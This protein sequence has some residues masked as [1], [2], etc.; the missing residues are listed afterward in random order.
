M[1]NLTDNPDYGA[2]RRAV[3]EDISVRMERLLSAKIETLPHDQGF[4]KG[5]I[6]V[7][8]FLVRD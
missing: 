6:A 3:K 8:D 7:N 1:E 5:M 4:I 2:L